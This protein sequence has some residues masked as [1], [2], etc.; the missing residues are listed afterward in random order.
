[1][2]IEVH[3]ND[4][5][6]RN[7]FGTVEIDLPYRGLSAENVAVNW[8]TETGKEVTS[9]QIAPPNA[10]DWVKQNEN[11]LNS[12]DIESIK[13]NGFFEIAYCDLKHTICAACGSS[14]TYDD[15]GN[16]IS[17]L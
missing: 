5:S 2:K 14:E 12:S 4:G 10:V 13:E 1:M 16:N 8:D 17:A 7:C 11:L 15:E 6:D 3:C 9:V